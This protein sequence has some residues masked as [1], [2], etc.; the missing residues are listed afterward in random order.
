MVAVGNGSEQLGYEFIGFAQTQMDIQRI[1]QRCSE[2]AN[3]PDI[4]L[5][6]SDSIGNSL[7]VVSVEFLS[8]G[9]SLACPGLPLVGDAFD[10]DWGFAQAEMDSTIPGTPQF[11]LP[12]GRFETYRDGDIWGYR[13]CP[14]DDH[15]LPRAIR[16]LARIR[17]TL[18]RPRESEILGAG[19]EA[20]VTAL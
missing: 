10:P 11:R 17:E 4:F 12:A 2:R 16:Q 13:M 15:E 6:S 9:Q 14:I 20:T 3:P 5:L 19:V 7:L 1:C 18:A 8:E